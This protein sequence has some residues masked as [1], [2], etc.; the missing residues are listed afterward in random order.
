MKD[1]KSLNAQSVKMLLQS[2]E[3]QIFNNPSFGEVRAVELNGVP[4]MVGKDVAAILGYTNP[5]KA[6]RDHVD[7]E[8]KGVDES[9]TVNGT[10]P[11]LI[12]ESGVYSLILRSHLPQ[13][14][15]FKKWVTS[16]VLPSIRKRGTY[17]TDNFIEQTLADPDYAIRVIS[18]WK[19][20]RQKR[21]RKEVGE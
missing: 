14:K 2:S 10:S 12:N 6:I 17:M 8:D 18:E 3:M 1:Q 19:E 11:I 7:D 13:A 16:E 21:F 5:Q 20:E 9:F 15:V 4:Y